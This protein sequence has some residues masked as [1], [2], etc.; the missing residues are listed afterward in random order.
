LYNEFNYLLLY[1]FAKYFSILSRSKPNAKKAGA[2]KQK[3]ANKENAKNEPRWS[4][5]LIIYVISPTHPHS[6][7]DFGIEHLSWF[8][9]K[10]EKD[11][12]I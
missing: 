8:L 12:I 1:T 7:H 4:V 2:L 11:C 3:T 6:F 10:K 5:T 9:E